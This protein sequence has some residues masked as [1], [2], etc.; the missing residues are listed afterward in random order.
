MKKICVVCGNEFNAKCKT[1]ICCSFA[2]KE[3]R[4][5]RI[6]REWRRSHPEA[7][8]EYRARKKNEKLAKKLFKAEQEKPKEAETS[9]TLH[10]L[11]VRDDDPD[12]IKIYANADIIT[13]ITMLARELNNV[14]VDDPM[15]TYGKLSQIR[16]TEKYYKLEEDTFKRKRLE[17]ERS[18]KGDS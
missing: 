4:R 5:R 1:H 16:H 14:C 2:C 15:F 6:A 7:N 8:K 11:D 3:E 13:Q 17:H 18:T 9:W 10:L 12:W